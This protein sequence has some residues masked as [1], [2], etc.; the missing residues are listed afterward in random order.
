MV[1]ITYLW[2]VNFIVNIT[3]P[4]YTYVLYNNYI[5]DIFF[6]QNVDAIYYRR[7]FIGNSTER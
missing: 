1:E 4:L 3:H 5:T 2:L 6:W 7:Y